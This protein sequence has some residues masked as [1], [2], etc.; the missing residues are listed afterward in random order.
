[1]PR[2]PPLVQKV[3]VSVFSN[4]AF[5]RHT[6]KLLED[7]LAAQQRAE[8][9]ELK[10][11]EAD[12]VKAKVAE[13]QTNSEALS[14]AIAEAAALFLKQADLGIEIDAAW[15]WTNADRPS[16]KLTLAD[17]KT[18]IAVEMF[19]ASAMSLDGAHAA[20]DR[21]ILPGGLCPFGDRLQ[22]QKIPSFVDTVRERA[23]FAISRLR[24]TVAD[25]QQ[26]A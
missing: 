16:L 15:D 8:A 2:V 18:L 1:M 3:S 22:P 14:R 21:F 9:A 5:Q 6:V 4:C 23:D 17:L 7:Q 25:K 26:A 19:R 24:A 10:A 20:D 12:R 13:W 11:K